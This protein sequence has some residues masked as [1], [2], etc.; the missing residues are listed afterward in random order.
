MIRLSVLCLLSSAL[1]VFSAPVEVWLTPQRAE[2]LKRVSSRPYVIS[3]ERIDDSTVVYRWTNGLHGACTTQRVE[4]VL[5]KPAKN[6]WREKLDAKDR[7]KQ[8]LLDDLK[9]VKDKPNKK[10][11]EEIILKHGKK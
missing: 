11:L 3:Q 6:A 5:G 1:C 2:Q 10:N 9:A 4:R 7:E 8:A